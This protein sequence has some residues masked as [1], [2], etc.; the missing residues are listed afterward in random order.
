MFQKHLLYYIIGGFI[1]GVFIHS[2]F[3]TVWSFNFELPIFLLVLS[4]MLFIVLKWRDAT[5]SVLMLI[6]IGMFFFGLG[7]LRSDFANTSIKSDLL[8]KQ[9]GQTTT[10]IGIV[11]DDPDKR[12]ANTKLTVK[13]DKLVL[14]NK[15]IGVESKV[16]VT[17]SPYWNYNYGDEL[18]ITGELKQPENFETATGRVFD[19]VSYLNKDGIFYQIYQPDIEILSRGN[20][21]FFRR[22]LFKLKYFFIRRIN[23]LFP[24]PEAALLGGEL[25]GE[26]N[27]LPEKLQEDFRTT[28]L[29]HI[30]VLSGYN[31]TIV[32]DVIVRVFSFLPMVLGFSMASIGIILF[33]IL[34]GAGATIV[35]AS[36]MA[37]LVIIARVFGR[38]YYVG[39]ALLLAAFLMVIHNPKIL[40]FDISFQLSFLATFGLLYLSPIL[41]RLL[42]FLPKKF[43]I[44]DSAIATI[45]AQIFVFPLLVYYMGEL[46]LVAV[47]ANI[48]VLV[49]IPL[50]MLFGFLS[51]LFGFLP[52]FIGMIFS[53]PTFLLLKYQTVIV[54]LFSSVPY[55]KILVP[56][57]SILITALIYILIL[58]FVRFYRQKLKINNTP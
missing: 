8:N 6:C 11:V 29:I 21:N 54:D 49:I 58:S 10:F 52:F 45:S 34:T 38:Q 56:Q 13:I 12:I 25:F 16:L 57:F 3:F 35:R 9:V 36:I 27:S 23:R 22:N 53:V 15:E 46:S 26:K 17:T 51:S 43:Q 32:A 40:L 50:T 47:P 44:R 41:E 39:R 4:S 28:G 55:S 33:A 7:L 37:L 1:L 20:G 42:S 24:Q 31:V 19:Y 30:V 18:K 48:L 2:V 5:K 14:P